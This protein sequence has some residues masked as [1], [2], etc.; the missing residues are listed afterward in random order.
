MHNYSSI[1]LHACVT[2]LTALSYQGQSTE[3]CN[4]CFGVC[5]VV[6]EDCDLLLRIFIR[7]QIIMHH[8][9]DPNYKYH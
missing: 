7:I 6:K 2:I 1:E 4:K 8:F 9:V 5:I 3:R